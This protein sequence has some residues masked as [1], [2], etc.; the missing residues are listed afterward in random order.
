MDGVSVVIYSAAGTPQ[1]DAR[2]VVTL[3]AEKIVVEDRAVTLFDSN[4]KMFAKLTLDADVN[5][6][7][8]STVA[9]MTAQG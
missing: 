7:R 8:E 9:G 3:A 5:L 4:G 2:G 1:K 6:L